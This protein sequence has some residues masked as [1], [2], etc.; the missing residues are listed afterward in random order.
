M[1]TVLARR[2]C[3]PTLRAGV[4]AMV[5][6][7]FSVSAHAAPAASQDTD[8]SMPEMPRLEVSM[9]SED[10][11][12]F[13]AK[14]SNASETSGAT[15]TSGAL[16][17]S[18]ATRELNQRLRELT[19][20][21]DLTQTLIQGRAQRP[22]FLE[23]RVRVAIYS[24]DG[25]RVTLQAQ[26]NVTI[27]KDMIVFKKTTRS[28]EDFCTTPC[29]LEASVGAYR[30]AVA[31][32]E[33]WRK[34]RTLDIPRRIDI[35][36]DSELWLKRKSRRPARAGFYTAMA[37]S[38]VAGILVGILSATEQKDDSL[39]LSPSRGPL[40]GTLSAGLILAGV[41]FFAGGMLSR[42]IYEVEERPYQPPKER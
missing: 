11:V 41:G 29:H 3:L 24:E 18:D 33:T 10:A 39:M 27:G 16:G 32:G 31:D 42:D 1:T 15:Q 36:K 25:E 40:M 12:L 26:R 19:E 14:T 2:L 9:T 4:L 17:A 38:A 37:A 22:L 23:K 21:M 6:L 34:A 28:Y 7:A 20:R 13:D 5:C 8:F 30:F 35:R